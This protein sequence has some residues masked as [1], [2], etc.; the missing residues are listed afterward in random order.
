ML[1]RDASCHNV[2][3]SNMIQMSSQGLHCTAI[4]YISV[5]NVHGNIPW[6]LSM[7]FVHSVP[8]HIS[9]T[10][11]MELFHGHCPW[12]LS[13]DSLDNLHRL[14]KKSMDSV[15]KLHGFHG[16]VPWTYWKNST[17]IL[18]KLHGHFPWIHWKLSSV[19]VPILQPDNVHGFHGLCPLIPWTF[20]TGSMDFL[21]TGYH[22]AKGFVGNR[23]GNNVRKIVICFPIFSIQKLAVLAQK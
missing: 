11:S 3:E 22:H 12:I 18:E 16:K 4:C 7:D 14:W 6:T 9:W 10:L 21:Q 17:D 23:G 20:S 15:E 1:T 13:T 19:F 5:D 8:V 2:H